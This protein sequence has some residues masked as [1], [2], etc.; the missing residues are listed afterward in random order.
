MLKKIALAVMLVCG[1]AM[2]QNT[3]TLDPTQVYNTG[4]LVNWN[5]PNSNGNNTSSPWV[6]G[7]YQQQL[8][9]W[10][11]GGPGNCGPTPTVTPGNINFSYGMTDIYQVT[12]VAAALPNSGTGLVV[13]GFN[14]GFSAKNGNG[15]DNGQQD[16]LRAYVKFYG[17]SG[18]EVQNYDYDLNYKF[19]WT[20]FNFSKTFDTPYAT[21]DLTA[22]RYGFVGYDTNFWAGTYGPEITN[23][24]FSLKYSVDPCA[25]NVLS[26]PTCPGYLD[27]L[28]KLAPAPTTVASDPITTSSTSA[29]STTTIVNDPVASTVSVT[30]TTNIGQPTIVSAP[31][32]TTTFSTAASSSQQTQKES[33]GSSSNTSL[34]LSLISKNQEKEKEIAMTA[35]QNA[36]QAAEQAGAQAQ[37]EA[38]SI[39]SQS[40][41]NSVTAG[42]AAVR[43]DGSSNSNRGGSTSVANSTDLTTQSNQSTQS[44]ILGPTQSSSSSSQQQ[45]QVSILAP[46]V[47]TS[48]V[49]SMVQMTN[50]TVTNNNETSK[51]TTFEMPLLAPAPAP[52]VQKAQVTVQTASVSQPVATVQTTQDQASTSVLQSPYTLLPPQQSTI[53]PYVAPIA[54]YELFTSTPTQ[55]TQTQSTQTVQET[56][57]L[58][59][60]NFLTDKSNPL[61]DIVE[62]KQNIP[63]NSTIATVGP[64]VNRNAGDNDVAGGISINK[65]ALA[66]VGY[67]D[68]LN[69]T[70]RDAAFYAPKEVY[71]NQ[72]NVDNARALRTLTNDSKHREMVEMQYAR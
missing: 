63:Q 45:E 24:S 43:T 32:S 2:A 26:S 30:S 59:S 47:T 67:S 52:V 61:T 65:M 28:A 36:I 7:V 66:P 31:S 55:P 68:Y 20:Y 10:G 50:P 22:A 6:N 71:R 56:V 40:V 48:Q 51:T 44:L 4:N 14:F 16:Y 34:A 41:A 27:A 70:L 33:S 9:C 37:Q 35:S 5:P 15:W 39:A 54:S 46:A 64:S 25:S 53:Q 57:A 19:N 18:N 29:S 21:K 1:V 23:I 72:R 49:L 38:V 12:S 3:A 62:G 17:P 11:P 58:L 69:L 60:P 42:S 13:K 8:T